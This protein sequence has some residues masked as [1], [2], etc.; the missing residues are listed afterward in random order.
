MVAYTIIENFFH[1]SS[2]YVKNQEWCHVH[3]ILLLREGRQKDLWNLL[4]SSYLSRFSES[5]CLQIRFK[6]TLKAADINAMHTYAHT[7]TYT[8]YM[9][10][11]VFTAALRCKSP[12]HLP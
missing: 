4:A 7:Y 2:T 9:R 8:Q 6:V 1:I 10:S 12:R 11:V 3:V 5:T